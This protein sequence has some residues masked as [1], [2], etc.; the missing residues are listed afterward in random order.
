MECVRRMRKR[1]PSP[2]L[3]RDIDGVPSKCCTGCGNWKAA[4][5]ANFSPYKQGRLGLHP[6][7]RSCLSA[8]NLKYYYANTPDRKRQVP[9]RLHEGVRQRQCTTCEQWKTATSDF[10][11]PQRGCRLG[12]R[13]T[14]RDCM[15]AKSLAY[16]EAHS[17]EA[18][19]R[20][21]AWNRQNKDRHAA[22]LRATQSKRRGAE[23]KFNADDI[24]AKLAKQSNRCYY[25]ETELDS[26]YHID[27][28]VSLAKGGRNDAANIVIACGRCN[29]KKGAKDPHVFLAKMRAR[30]H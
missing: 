22:H 6:W 29:R 16:A 5:A 10:F 3:P 17:E 23:G 28:F 15:R 2:I 1:P 7:C 21:L 9:D 25:C 13:P 20:V 30:T 11:Q 4:T 19:E 8:N 26:G 12:L 24:R 14:C 27:H 18:V